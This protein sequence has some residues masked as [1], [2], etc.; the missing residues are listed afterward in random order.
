[1]PV[2]AWLTPATCLF[3]ALTCF[4]I[5]RHAETN[6]GMASGASNMLA[7]IYG[8]RDTRCQEWNVWGAVTFDWTK[9]GSSMSTTGSFPLLKTNIQKL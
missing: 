6:R 4:N 8:I 9:G 1:V 5:T 2:W 7:S 3:L